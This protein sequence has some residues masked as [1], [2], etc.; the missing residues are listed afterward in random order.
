[1][2]VDTSMCI[3]EYIMRRSK[4][5]F[6]LLSILRLEL[7][8][9]GL[10]ASPCTCWAILLPHAPLPLEPFVVAFGK[11]QKHAGLHFPEV[12]LQMFAFWDWGRVLTRMYKAQVDAGC[13]V[14]PAWGTHLSSQHLGGRSRQ[15][16]KAVH[17]YTEI[18]CLAWPTWDL[19]SKV[20]RFA[21][22]CRFKN[23]GTFKWHSICGSSKR[24]VG[25][26]V[27]LVLNVWFAFS[28]LVMRPLY[29]MTTCSPSP[30]PWVK[31][32]FELSVGFS[33]ILLKSWSSFYTCIW[34]ETRTPLLQNVPV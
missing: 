28:F 21:F 12:R 23:V 7:R 25:L 9:S 3:M 32:S 34:L 31:R 30:R 11:S 2:Y 26:V 5:S 27:Y 16:F 24:H 8:S 10:A 6:L 17:R 1:M 15:E 13:R 29:S 22:F 20:Q 4:D 14:N 18:S 19:I 33:F